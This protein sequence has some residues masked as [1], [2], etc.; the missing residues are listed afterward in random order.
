MRATLNAFQLLA[1]T[2][3]LRRPRC[4]QR[5]NVKRELRI[6][7]DSFRPLLRGRRRRSVASLPGLAAAL[8]FTLAVLTA[9]IAQA[10]PTN[11]TTLSGYAGVGATNGTGPGALFSGPQSVA[12]G[13][14]GNIYVADSGNNIIRVITPAGT[15]STLA[16]QPGVTGTNDGTGSSAL[17]NQ[18]SGIA[19]DAATNVYVSDYG[20]HTI[21]QITPAGA[22]TTIAGTAGVS[23]SLNATGTNALFFHP[24]GLALDSATNLYVADY[25]NHLIREI[26]PARVVSTLAGSAGVFGYTNGTGTAAVFYGPEAVAVDPAGNV[27]VADTGNAA[28]RLITPGG[29]VS[30][31]AGSPGSLGSADGTGTNALFFQP[32]G[33]AANNAT[34]IYVSDYFGNS[35]RTVTT[36]GVVTTLAGSPS[37]AGSVDGPN[38]T[39]RFSAP[40]GLA[41][42]AAGTIY[43][44]DSANGAVRAVTPAGVVSTL[45]GSA[46]DGS[47]D[48]PS[49][50]ARFYLPQ[51]IAEDSS[52]NLFVAD[53]KNNTIR[54]I[55]V[56]GQVSVLAGATGVSGSTDAIGT[57]A[58]FAG[59]LGVAVDNSGNI[60]VADTGNSTIRKITPAGAVTTL[61]G[62][63]GTP[64]NADGQGT[65]AQFYTPQGVAVDSA[66]NIYVADTGN[67]TIR[68][69]TPGGSVSTLAGFAGAFG[70]NDGAT[71]N[72]RFNCPVGI[73]VNSSG[74]I[75]VTD[76]NN[77]TIRLVTPAGVVSTL[78][79]WA[80]IWGSADGTNS[81]ALFFAPAGIAVDSSTNLYV[82]D[83]AN[84]TLRK[85]APSGG[86]WIVSTLAGSP[87]VS[88]SSDGTLTNARFYNP[89]G[90]VINSAGYLFIAD[91]GN[92]TLRTS[93]AVASINWPNPPGIT[94]GTALSA[95]QLNATASLPG[96]FTYNPVA[97][98][99]LNAGIDTLSAYFTPTDTVNYRGAGAIASLA[100]SRAPLTVTAAN[101]RRAFGMPNP[102][103]TGTITGLQNN[104]NITADYNCAATPNSPAGA[105]SIVP[106]LVDPGDRQINYVVTLV[107]GTLS[108]VIAP[109]I[110]SET[111]SSNTFTFTW[112]ATSNQ[113]YQIQYTTNLAQNLWSNLGSPITATNS[114][115]SASNVITFPQQFF[116][117]VLYP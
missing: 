32:A 42:N 117:V 48:G 111:K 26:S 9:S 77:N 22:V 64:G 115:V 31:L 81:G 65:N 69:I 110:Q 75:F 97:G 18:P 59:P 4:V 17:F 73:T 50:S 5:R 78:A 35:L 88:G 49:V 7:H 13:P 54:K 2:A 112:S 107:N 90:L 84:N 76:Y 67:H 85:I 36:A 74:N 33:I 15:S 53:A 56:S 29:A 34:N 19:V 89:S 94:Y 82:T 37:S 47:I 100:V 87:G 83:S 10:Q 23:G 109:V 39:A 38:A 68:K 71:N 20:N 99:I 8:A 79:G 46:S 12:V 70:S 66:A 40:Q 103:F 98:A 91:S 61:A 3:R 55:T 30:L 1:G 105:Y 14:D 95:T 52:G 116:R 62:M 113:M 11:F 63:S 106:S 96:T 114:M 45:A 93:E 28:I 58:Q 104:D 92:N 25:G 80:G 108:V 27:Y 60:Y 21:R 72:A 101:A 16:G 43:V 102:A 57:N 24:M 44:A 86:N 51:S 41:V 6:G